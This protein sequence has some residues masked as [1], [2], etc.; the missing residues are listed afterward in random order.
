MRLFEWMVV[1][2][3]SAPMTLRAQSDVF[4]TWKEPGGS[5]IRV[6]HCGT[7]ICLKLV[8]ISKTAPARVDHHNPDASLRTRTLCG[9]LIG[10]GFKVSD[11]QHADGGT[12]YDPKSGKTY[13]GTL[14][15]EGGDLHLRGYVGFKALGRTEV[16][17]RSPSVDQC[18]A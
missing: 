12:L 11:A 3:L 2:F 14:W 8:G 7:D 6:E 5:V 16:W 13:H 17:Q 1:G 10:S 9:L 15:L 18:K 4:G